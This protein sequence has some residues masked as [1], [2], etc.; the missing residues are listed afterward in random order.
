MTESFPIDENI[1]VEESEQGFVF[2]RHHVDVFWN[3]ARLLHRIAFHKNYDIRNNRHF[4]FILE[5]LKM[6][7]GFM[8]KQL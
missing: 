5:L 3:I 7:L 4:F 1:Y 2:N 8:R 6:R